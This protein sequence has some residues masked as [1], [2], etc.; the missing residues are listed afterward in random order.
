MWALWKCHNNTQMYCDCVVD[1]VVVVV[2]CPCE[3]E[4][5]YIISLIRFRNSHEVFFLFW[6]RWHFALST[7][8]FFIMF[9]ACVHH[10]HTVIMYIYRQS[11]RK[12]P[13]SNLLTRLITTLVSFRS[14]STKA[15][16]Q[17]EAK[18]DE[19]LS[20][21]KIKLRFILTNELRTMPIPKVCRANAVVWLLFIII[22]MPSKPLFFF[23]F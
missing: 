17:I 10:V 8:I 19:Y 14:S 3:G 6:I 22:V 4:I 23:F 2:V 5:Y 21:P 16:E 13:D 12:F 7:S 1:V 11:K 15:D 20:I 9:H 18:F